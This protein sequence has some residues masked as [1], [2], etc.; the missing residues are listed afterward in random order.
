L[1]QA[2]GQQGTPTRC[3]SGIAV[4]SRAGTQT[5]YCDRFLLT[6]TGAST[7]VTMPREISPFCSTGETL[8]RLVAV[9]SRRRACRCESRSVGRSRVSALLVLMAMT[10]FE[11]IHVLTKFNHCLPGLT[12]SE[13]GCGAISPATGTKHEC[14]LL[15]WAGWALAWEQSCEGRDRIR[16]VRGSARAPPAIAL[17]GLDGMPAGNAAPLLLRQFGGRLLRSVRCPSAGFP[18]DDGTP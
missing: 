15:V 2:R 3:A 4:R 18:P 13:C 11:W 8:R 9:C 1:V 12:P 10:R 14:R 17:L 6:F 5:T 7:D 16:S